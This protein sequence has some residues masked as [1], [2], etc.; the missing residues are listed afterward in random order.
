M[1]YYL[2]FKSVAL[3]GVGIVSV[4][5]GVSLAGA[6]AFGMAGLQA[7]IIHQSNW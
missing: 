2:V 7:I 3:L 5:H 6:V 1:K 4:Y